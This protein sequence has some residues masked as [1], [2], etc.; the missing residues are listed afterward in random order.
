MSQIKTLK[1]DGQV[2]EL[3]DQNLLPNQEVYLPVHTLQQC[4]D[5][6]CDMTVRGAPAIGVA[7]AYGMVLAARKLPPGDFIVQYQ[8]AGTY[9]KGAR[10]TAVNLRWAVNRMLAK[11]NA[12]AGSP[13]IAMLAALEAEAI[14]IH[15]ADAAANRS[16]GAHLLSLL[17]PGN[18][19]LTHCNAG[20]LATSEFGT[21][22]SVFFVAQEQ[23]VRLKAYADETRPR[24]QGARLTAFELQRAGVDVTLICDNTAAVLMAAGKIDAVITGADRIAANGDTANK[25]GTFGVSIL[26][27]HFGIPLYIAAP[28]A[29]IDIACPC[30]TDIP[31]E[32]R[33]RDEVIQINGE[34]VAPRDVDVFC[35]AFDVT[36]ATHITAIVTENGIAR[37]PYAQSLPTLL[38]S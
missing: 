27:R 34:Y 35:P 4:Y 15:R 2:L 11:A 6:I 10:P 23:G 32:Q 1:W 5:A 29:T 16:I 30:G 31:V 19:V 9:L 14:A 3:L 20:A 12:C 33:S 25:I 28:T 21:A 13:H 17:C 7:A 18:A 37:A 8:Q 26:A 36:P 38:H 22:L 24:L